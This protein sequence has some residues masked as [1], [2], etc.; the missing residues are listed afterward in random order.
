MVCAAA[1]YCAVHSAFA[2]KPAKRTAARLFGASAADAFYRIFFNAQSVVGLA[3][4][5]LYGRRLPDRR[6][7]EVTGAREIAMRVVQA[8]GIAWGIWTA[9]Q[10]GITELLGV[11]PL[12]QAMVNQSPDPPEAQGPR[13][14]GGKGI[15]GPFLASRHPLNFAPIPAFWA[16][17]LMTLNRLVFN[18][19]GTVYLVL[20]SI[21]EEARLK[22]RYG[23]EYEAY[24][25]SGVP[26]FLPD[27]RRLLLREPSPRV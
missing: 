14:D 26:F 17:P 27:F 19:V 6:L 13:L 4:L 5:A 25:R 12:L 8:S 20:G 18:V 7:Y 11:K 10:V 15:R 22:G 24:T 23:A 1:I 9:R 3:A 16:T 21:H 2:S